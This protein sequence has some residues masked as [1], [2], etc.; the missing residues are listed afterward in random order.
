MPFWF[1]SC[2]GIRNGNPCILWWGGGSCRSSLWERNNGSLEVS[3]H[4]TEGCT[5]TCDSSI[6]G[7]GPRYRMWSRKWCQSPFAP[8]CPIFFPPTTSSCLSCLLSFFGNQEKQ[9][10]RWAALYHQCCQEPTQYCADWAL[11]QPALYSS[12]CQHKDQ[13]WLVS[14]RV[15]FNSIIDIRLRYIV[16]TLG[17]LLDPFFSR[18]PWT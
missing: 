18:L 9:S 4:G 5:W 1:S 11:L 8:P 17:K 15:G 14:I 2:L 6:A 7:A 10:S 12:Q 3:H 13:L 16:L